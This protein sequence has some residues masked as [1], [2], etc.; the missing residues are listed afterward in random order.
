[1]GICERKMEKC[2]SESVNYSLLDVEETVMMV[3][4]VVQRFE[5][6]R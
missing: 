5:R 4:V 3:G 6:Q 1:M 2:D